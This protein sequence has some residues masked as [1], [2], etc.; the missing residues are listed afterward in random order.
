MSLGRAVGIFVTSYGVAILGYLAL[1]GAAGRL[2]GASEFGYFVAALTLTTTLGQ[3]GLL[4]VHRSGLRE[5]ARLDQDDVEQLAELRGGVRATLTISLPAV[6]LVSGVVTWILQSDEPPG[7]RL[8]MS[9][10]IAALVILSGQQKVWANYLRGFGHVKFASMLEGRSGGAMVAV[11]QAALVCLVW[12]FVPSWG[13]AGAL[14]AVAIG[15]LIPD[16]LAWRWVARTWG[17]APPAGALWHDLRRVARRD[18][19]F[20]SVQ[21][22]TMLNASV[23][24]WIAGLLLTSTDTSMFG[25]AQRISML[26]V[27]P[28]TAIQVVFSPMISR[29]AVLSDRLPLQ[30]T[31]RTGAPLASLST[32][33]LWLPI[34]LLPQLVLRIVF[35]PGFSEAAAPMVLLCTALVV[36]ALMGLAGLTLSMGHREGVVASTQW[37]T[38]LVR[39]AVGALVAWQLGLVALAVSSLVWS[40]VYYVWIWLRVRREMGVNTALT[41]HPDLTLVREKAN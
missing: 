20:A 3:L 28:M 6:G 23:E 36:N 41:V 13:L 39:V 22:A 26:I 24:V 15:Y 9:V 1:N 2:L 4:G 33:L 27:L 16:V 10:G 35:G 5:A 25:A 18:W 38:L 30:N 31:L 12:I 32:V 40:T 37:W 19:R 21:V 17:H 7:K 11:L 14:L 29:Q 8:L 34:V